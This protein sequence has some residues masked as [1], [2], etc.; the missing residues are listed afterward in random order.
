[1]TQNE[2]HLMYVAAAILLTM[3]LPVVIGLVAVFREK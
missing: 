1:M 3:V 2:F